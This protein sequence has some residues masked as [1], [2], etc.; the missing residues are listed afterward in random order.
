MA[1]CHPLPAARMNEQVLQALEED[2]IGRKLRAE[3]QATMPTTPRSPPSSSTSPPP[4][5]A[6][7]PPGREAKQEVK[8]DA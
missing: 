3:T 7:Q 4:E 8:K 6:V 1:L 5:S 2:K